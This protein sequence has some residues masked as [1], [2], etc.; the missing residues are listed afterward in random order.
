MGP[1]QMTI[2]SPAGMMMFEMESND[3]SNFSFHQVETKIISHPVCHFLRIPFSII[4]CVTE[5]SPVD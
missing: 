3:E 1:T 5:T 4:G 2:I